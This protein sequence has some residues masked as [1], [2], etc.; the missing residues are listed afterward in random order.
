[1]FDLPYV[2]VLAISTIDSVI[3]YSTSSLAPIAIVGNIHYSLITDISWMG[4]KILATSSSDGY[5]SF[6]KMETNELG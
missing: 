1:M 2:I 5:C 6:I 3:I 4:G